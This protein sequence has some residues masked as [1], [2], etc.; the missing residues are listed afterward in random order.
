VL[1]NGV[2]TGVEV[3]HAMVHGGPWP[4]TSSPHTTSVGTR[5]ITRWARPVCYQDAPDALLPL[6]L[7]RDNPLR[8]WRWTDG[9]PGWS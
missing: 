7:R 5:A 6:E 4:A 9:V 2:P 3:G 8:L 1:F